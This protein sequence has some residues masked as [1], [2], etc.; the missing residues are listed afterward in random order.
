MTRLVAGD[1]VLVIGGSGFIGSHLMGPL[2]DAGLET[3]SF[4]LHPYRPAMGGH[5]PDSSV[6]G[7]FRDTRALVEAMQGC[8]AVLHLAAAHHDF[9]LTPQTF[10]SVNVGGAHALV[11]AMEKAGIGNLCFYSSVAV[12]GAEHALPDETSAP[13]PVNDYGRTKLQ[14]ERVYREWEAAGEG[15]GQDRRCLIIRPAVVF[16]PRNF[17][18]VHRLIQQIDKRRFLPVGSGAN[19]K[20]M[21]YVENLVAA[22]LHLWTSEVDD[23]CEGGPEVYNYV[24][25]PDLTSRAVISEI[26]RALGRREP[27]LRVPL[28]PALALT[29]P[30]DLLAKLTGRNLPITSE[31]VRKLAGTETAFAADRVRATGFQPQTTLP[32][33][34]R[35]M[36]NWYQVEGRDAEPVVH[37]PPE[38]CE[39]CET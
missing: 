5:S 3:V 1:R 17:A 38:T 26:Y 36:V 16:G 11:A 20:S 21:C 22:I 10:T 13:S 39:S 29:S 14:A 31:R 37:L 15:A 4:D 12:Y 34:L 27:R 32:D 35:R 25:K 19:R 30:F 7:D 8:S 2:R 28:A 24:D 9:G 6:V 18:N 33:G 23:A